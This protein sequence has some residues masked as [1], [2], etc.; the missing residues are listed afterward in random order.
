VAQLHSRTSDRLAMSMASLEELRAELVSL[1]ELQRVLGWKIARDWPPRLW[2]ADPIRWAIG[3]IEAEPEELFWRPWY[4]RMRGYDGAYCATAGFK[5]PAQDG[6]LEVGYSVVDSHHRRG[7]A[8]EVT[9]MLMEWARDFAGISK[10]CAHTLVGDPASAGVLLKNGFVMAGT[11]VDPVD[12]E[13]ARFERC[14]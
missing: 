12:G 3:K 5:G 9:G 11:V 10:F 13:I 8:T 7:I 1:A 14:S 6:M 2:E 4:V